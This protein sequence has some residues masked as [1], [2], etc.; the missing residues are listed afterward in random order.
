MP[1]KFTRLS[2]ALALC[3]VLAAAP[4]ASAQDAAPPWIMPDILA[5]A[6][7]EGAVTI[8]SSINEG[9]LLPLWKQFEDATGI[10]VQIVRASDAQL[11]SRIAIEGRARQ[12]SWD[13]LIT[14][15]VSQL[16]PDLLAPYE[17][18]EAA[19]LIPQARAKDGRWYGSSANYNAPAYNTNLVRKEDLPTSYEG[20]IAKKEW[21]GRVAIDTGDGQWLAG[22]FAHY[23]EEKGRKL[24]RDIVA[25]LEPVIHDGH[26]A[27]A[28]SL[29]A[30]EYMVALNNYINLTYNVRLGGAPVDVF[31]LEPVSFHMVQTGV[32]AFAAHPNAARL[33]ANFAVS[34][35]A[36]QFS[37]LSGRIPVRGDVTT[38]PPDAL[39]RLA[40][41]TLVA[42]AFGPDDDRKWKRTFDEIFRPR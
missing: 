25:A 1:R 32:S 7:A 24:V 2:G 20:F 6:R 29:G 22:M 34:R 11:N 41:R 36:Q 37:A 12:R 15:A 27:L 31:A 9:E 26:L 8:Y 35:Q 4:R 30:G 42:T 18:P 10:K 19:N 33:A 40:G 39:Q 21:R 23:G 3:G 5:A 38:T 17:I 13:T 28:R 16:P 14:T